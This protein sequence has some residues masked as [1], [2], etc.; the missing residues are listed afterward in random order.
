[1]MTIEQ[2]LKLLGLKPNFTK[3]EL[4]KAYRRLSKQ[5]HPD[6]S[7]GSDEKFRRLTEAVKLLESYDGVAVK[8]KSRYIFH[9]MNLFDYEI[10]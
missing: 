10:R 1:M 4:K 2:A 9:G 7:G 5:Y 8:R 6:V 3:Q